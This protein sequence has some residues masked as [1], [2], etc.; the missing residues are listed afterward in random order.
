MLRLHSRNR[1]LRWLSASLHPHQ[2]KTKIQF[3]RSLD[4][5]E[6]SIHTM[7]KILSILRDAESSSQ[8]EENSK[9]ENEHVI[10]HSL[11]YKDRFFYSLGNDVFEYKVVLVLNKL[12]VVNHYGV[13]QLVSPETTKNIFRQYLD[14]FKERYMWKTEGDHESLADLGRLFGESPLT[15]MAKLNAKLSQLSASL[16]VD[17]D[18]LRLKKQ[19]K[20][21]FPDVLFHQPFRLVTADPLVLRKGLSMQKH[22]LNLLV[23]MVNDENVLTT[24]LERSRSKVSPQT[25]QSFMVAQTMEGSQAFKILVKRYLRHLDPETTIHSPFEGYHLANTNSDTESDIEIVK[26]IVAS[27]SKLVERIL[28]YRDYKF[29]LLRMDETLQDTNEK[30]VRILAEIFDRFF[31]ACYKID[32]KYCNKWVENL[33]EFY[34]KNEQNEALF[35]E[36][37]KESILNF[38]Q[39]Y[40][41]SQFDNLTFKWDR[42][43]ERPG[44]A[45]KRPS[46][47]MSVP[48]SELENSKHLVR[49]VRALLATSRPFRAKV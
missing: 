1:G 10:S 21:D 38:R 9:E 44:H 24:F 30:V 11:S 18:E 41:G 12:E 42:R 47:K 36:L 15:T 46:S 6:S 8:Q 43:S 16:L 19:F 20:F 45:R 33:I 29:A 13:F 22:P 4:P 27:R 28:P 40:A 31:G 48:K 25:L 17:S 23:T 32:A 2:K 49:D 34:L 3:A 7:D 39:A 37:F 26:A 5:V 35:E 14:I